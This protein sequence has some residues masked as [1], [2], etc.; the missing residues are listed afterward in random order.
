MWANGNSALAEGYG[1][2]QAG[3]HD[4]KVGLYGLDVYAVDS[5]KNML[6]IL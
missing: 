2:I 3:G 6:Q 1:I 5:M 4:K